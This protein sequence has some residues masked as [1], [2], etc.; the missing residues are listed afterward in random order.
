MA[1]WMKTG[2]DVGIG[3]VAG[4]VDQLAQNQDDKR[5]K[6]K[7][8]AG[9]TLGMMQQIGTWVNYGVPVLA[10]V[11]T[12]MGWLKGEMATRVCTVGAQLA[13]RK[14]TWQFTKRKELPGY[15]YTGFRASAG[16]PAPR[17]LAPTPRTPPVG[18]TP[19][20]GFELVGVT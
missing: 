14:A 18:Q 8:D 12:A 3:G 4:A 2:M 15:A 17:P 11:A 19:K 7:A 13:G 6:E 10:I 20:P 9:E 5:A 1:D 16:T